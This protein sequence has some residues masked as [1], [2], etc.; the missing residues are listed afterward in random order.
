MAGVDLPPVI[1]QEGSGV[2]N[3]IKCLK[4]SYSNICEVES[5]DRDSLEEVLTC[6]FCQMKLHAAH[7]DGM[8]ELSEEYFLCKTCS[9]NAVV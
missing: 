5:C 9:I 2:Q 4:E 8:S 7:N 3:F 1:P 6:S